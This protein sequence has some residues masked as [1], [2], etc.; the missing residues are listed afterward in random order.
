[1]SKKN[2][3]LDTCVLLH[4]PD[5][6]YSFE[7]NNVYIPFVVLEELDKFKKNND[8]TGRNCRQVTR[9]LDELR[10][11]GHL[12]KGV[13]LENGGTLIVTRAYTGEGQPDLDMKINDNMIL[14]TAAVLSNRNREV[15]TILVT[16]DINLRVK[17]DANG[18]EAEAFGKKKTKNNH[19]DIYSGVAEIEVD[20]ESFIEFKRNGWTEF[21][22][23]DAEK[24]NVFPNQYLILE[25]EGTGQRTY[26][27]YSLKQ[28]RLVKLIDARDVFGIHAKSDEQRFALDALLNDEIKLVSLIGKAGTGKTLLAVASGLHKTLDEKIF[29]K[30][31]V[32]RPVMPMG[33]DIGYLPGDLKEKL[34]PW[35]QPI[36]DNLAFLFDLKKR[37]HQPAA[38][39]SKGARLHETKTAPTAIT[40]QSLIDDG[41]IQVEA[42]TYIR[43]RSIPEQ[44]M[45]I[46][47]AQNLTPH[48]IKTIIT[49]AGEG[50]KI[51][52]TGDT[53][54]IDSPYLDESSNGL[55]YCVE[56]MKSL[57][58]VAHVTLTQ[59]ERSELAEQ[60]SQLL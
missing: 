21:T 40:Q 29:T 47:E 11:K 22:I 39:K 56:R 9:M 51:V 23:E 48:E 38:K 2:Y 26:A 30:L 44:Y 50:T 54:Q 13:Q 5:S 28:N 60:G 4:D 27:R 19:S 55:A 1:M 43:G 20:A 33:K 53:Q 41:T 25:K 12:T 59:G 24:L 7:D 16:N 31:L 49:R 45:I 10:E 8:E 17:A 6:I 32:S 35:M 58:I 15:K 46:D 57:D 18:V 42:L 14:S 52:L 3:V 37:H 34:A 36:H